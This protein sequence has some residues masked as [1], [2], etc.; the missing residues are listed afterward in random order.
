MTSASS[1]DRLRDA[2]AALGQRIRTSREALGITQE[3]L[4]HRSG[5]SRNQV[6]NLENNRNNTRDAE[7]MHGPANPRLDTMWSVAAV[8]QISLSDLFEDFDEF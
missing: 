7:G 5:L 4:A 3:E 8:L 6:Q 1:R 2:S